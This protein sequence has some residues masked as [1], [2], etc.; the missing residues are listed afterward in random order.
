M[1]SLGDARLGWVWQVPGFLSCGVVSSAGGL[2][3]E[4]SV[5]E[6][7]RTTPVPLVTNSVSR[8]CNFTSCAKLRSNK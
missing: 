1:A 6:G 3:Q 2:S 8:W 4:L 5:F 7:E